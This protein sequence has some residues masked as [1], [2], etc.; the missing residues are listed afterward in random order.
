MGKLIIYKACKFC[1]NTRGLQA[2]QKLQILGFSMEKSPKISEKSPN[3][4]E[5]SS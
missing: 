1:K 5:E 4:F 2:F 3:I